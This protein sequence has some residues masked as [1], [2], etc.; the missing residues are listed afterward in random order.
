MQ[1]SGA[2]FN[3][4][5]S[6]L[7]FIGILLAISFLLYLYFSIL[8]M[9]IARKSSTPNA[10]LAWIPF[11]NLFLMCQIGRRPGWWVLLLLIPLV[12]LYFAALLWMSIAEMR[13]KP[14]WTGALM[15]APILN[16]L[17]LA[18]LAGGPK[19]T[20]G[21]T[22]EPKSCASCGAVAAAADPFCGRCGRALPPAAIGR[23]PMSKMALVGALMVVLVM[24]TVG[25][26]GWMAFG[27][28]MA[29]TPP[30]RQAPEMPQRLAG[31]LK[32]F[33]VDSSGQTPARPGSVITQ[34][35]Q[36]GGTKSNSQKLPPRWLPPGLDR[37]SLRS[38]ANA[39]TS[40]SYRPQTSASAASTSGTRSKEK[41]G[42]SNQVYV[43]VIDRAANQPDAGEEIAVNVTQATRG[44]R[45]GVRVDSPGG[46]VYVG[47]RIRTSQIVVF[48]LDKQGSGIVII[49][50]APSPD[51]QGV[52]ERL[53]TN[54]GNGQ[55]LNDYPEVQSSIW[56]LP[57]RQPDDLVLKEMNTMTRDEVFAPEDQKS[58]G[59]RN[60]QEAQDMANG[61]SFFIP[62]RMTTARYSDGAQREWNALVCDFGS[63]RA[64]WNT[65]MLLRWT[66]GI[67]M[68]STTVLGEGAL[69]L[70]SDGQ[71]M[72]I[73]Q[74]GPY[75]V[76]LGG[77]AAASQER[78][79]GWGN[80]FQI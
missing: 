71:R 34:D 57:Q 76:F 23:M 20:P 69:Y 32:E 47:S 16:L 70:D 59:S 63:T 25:G 66:A 30:P 36:P 5:S 2:E 80:K 28:A 18:Y 1:T 45:G 67:G 3:P 60:S 40:V 31:T 64:A 54:V 21:T 13:G 62:E 14:V 8:L 42:A 75:L 22:S 51:T 55:G 65:W 56:T 41:P 26:A 43:H 37:D 73:F 74:K 78:L 6:I 24:G 53:A 35:F 27:S 49:I 17:T 68:Q 4:L 58:S 52:A 50:Y 48:V 7:G 72:L 15:L 29:Y 79:V 46:D 12:N 9:I 44:E 33:P 11:V 38:R 19:T 61:I 10:G 77:P 39:M